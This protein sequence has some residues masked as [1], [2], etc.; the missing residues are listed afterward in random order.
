MRNEQGKNVIAMFNENIYIKIYYLFY[1]G[2]SGKIIVKD[3]QRF[4]I[5]I[6]EHNNII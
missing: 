2:E 5:L 6:L 3:T 1:Y 4:V